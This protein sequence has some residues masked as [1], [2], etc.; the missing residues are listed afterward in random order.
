[1]NTKLKLAILSLLFVVG[2]IAIWFVYRPSAKN[3]VPN[4]TLTSP[5]ATVIAQGSA[6]YQQ[7]CAV[8]HGVNGEGQVPTAPF[9]RDETGRYTAPP[10]NETGHTWH[11]ADDLLIE[12]VHDG[13]MGQPDLFHEMPAFG[14]QLTDEQIQAVI[15][16]IKTLWTEDQRVRQAETT[17]LV[18]EQ[19]EA[20]DSH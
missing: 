11:H 4:S 5:P 2:S 10:H 16:Y 9:D 6:I 12:I 1:M 15:I 8:C 7:H 17:Q 18:R 14:E 19:N 3:D 13:G 20:E